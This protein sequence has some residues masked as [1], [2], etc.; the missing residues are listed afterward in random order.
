MANA[1]DN[2]N[3]H[4][5]VHKECQESM[6]VLRQLDQNHKILQKLEHDLLKDAY[7]NN[8]ERFTK[9][10]DVISGLVRG[11][12]QIQHDDP[13]LQVSGMMNITG[14]VLT[15]LGA[16]G[17]AAGPAGPAVVAAGSVITLI[18]AIIPI[19]SQANQP[20][21][22]DTIRDAVGVAI[23]DA[24]AEY[25]DDD[26]HA[27]L[28]GVQMEMHSRITFLQT[29][30]DCG[31]KVEPAF[32]PKLTDFNFGMRIMG[33]LKYYIQ[34]Y[35]N[36]KK[37]KEAKRVV[38]YM[39]YYC[40]VGSL[41]RF[42]LT[43]QGALCYQNEMNNAH[44][45]VLVLA[46]KYKDDE[47]VLNLKCITEYKSFI[48]STSIWR[49][50]Q[51]NEVL[52]IEE[53]GLLHEY[54]EQIGCKPLIRK[55]DPKQEMTVAILSN[56]HKHIW[57]VSSE[58][59]LFGNHPVCVDSGKI[60]NYGL[61]QSIPCGP[62]KV[63]F[64]TSFGYL[65]LNRYKNLNSIHG[66][67]KHKK[68][69]ET[70]E[71]RC[72]DPEENLYGL[73]CDNHKFIRSHHG[74]KYK[75][76]HASSDHLGGDETF[77][78]IP[79]PTMPKY[80][81]QNRRKVAIMSWDHHFLCSE[82]HAHARRVVANR[83]TVGAWE[84]FESIPVSP[85]HVAFKTCHGTFVQIKRDND[86]IGIHGNGKEIRTWETF[87]IICVD[88]D[89]NTYAFKCDNGKFMHASWGG[90]CRAFGNQKGRSVHERFVIIP[91]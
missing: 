2:E 36:S 61:F 49:Y 12:P 77:I 53:K 50:I 47:E 26:I 13:I 74:V 3:L 44:K 58:P 22:A 16:I 11:I 4:R 7:A 39:Y 8:M 54:R 84:V 30:R 46:A 5:D 9:T 42:A 91:L 28:E 76:M 1:P 64:K 65:Q 89:R 75:F 83:D 45:A 80:N 62:N 90:L 21:L 34:K 18:A 14:S 88:G 35:Q 19:F 23:N 31:G 85:K 67:G 72:V 24:F 32:A 86:G 70:F 27:D 81:H 52:S 33:K 66:N 25:K 10:V 55:Y 78:F 79:I 82:K 38:R 69:W 73:K 60:C 43:L 56:K 40:L 15:G 71:I 29:I 57:S 17:F 63:A 41:R 51:S 59:C 87:E 20:S 37:Q 68:T 48:T 6:D